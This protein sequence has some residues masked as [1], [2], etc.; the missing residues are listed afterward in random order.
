MEDVGSGREPFDGMDDQ[1]EVI[2]LGS[3]GIEEIRRHAARGAV[4]H[5]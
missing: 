5:G 1:V 4:E 2:E 3:R